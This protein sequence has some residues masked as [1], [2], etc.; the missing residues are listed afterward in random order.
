MPIVPNFLY[1]S[2]LARLVYSFT[3]NLYVKKILGAIIYLQP[4]ILLMINFNFLLA[5]IQ[6]YTDE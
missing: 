3:V 1:L 5:S 2:D 4:F 6:L